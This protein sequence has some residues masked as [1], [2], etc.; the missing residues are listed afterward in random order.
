MLVNEIHF[1]R[2]GT[3]AY[4]Q[5]S[6]SAG[7]PQTYLLRALAGQTLIL[8]VSSSDNDVF[9]DLLGLES[10][11]RL[12]RAA[13]KIS[14]WVGELPLD[15]PYQVTLRTDNPDTTYFLH[16]EIPAVIQF[17]P[18]AYSARVD[19]YV[20]VHTDKYPDLMTR[21]RYLAHAFAGQTMTVTLKSPN[22]DHLAIGIIGQKDGQA[23]IRYQIKNNG[24]EVHLPATQGY[25][26]D[27]YSIS[28][29]STAYRLEITIR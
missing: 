21:V 1:K 14:H 24:G 15:Q 13:D 3:S 16:I 4:I 29:R 17:E 25:Y 5:K 28:G 22:L 18:G 6:I 12:V 27:V 7:N 20:A 9:L 23:Y 10:N 11:V 8:G 19:G 26:L 2:G